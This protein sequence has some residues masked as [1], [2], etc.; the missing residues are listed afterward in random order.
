LQ[1]GQTDAAR[2]FL[3]EALT[4]EPSN[5]YA[6]INM[7]AVYEKS[8]QP[9][10]AAV[11]YQAVIA[12]GTTALADQASAPDR[13][14]VPLLQLAREGLERLAGTAQPVKRSESNTWNWDEREHK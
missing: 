1:A 12:G 4:I 10:Q 14:G 13:V 9:R 11:M 2:V 5:P 8:G 7:A 3:E 6:L